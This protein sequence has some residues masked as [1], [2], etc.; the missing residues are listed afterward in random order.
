[1]RRALGHKSISQQRK[2]WLDDGDDLIINVL[3]RGQAKLIF[4]DKF[5]RQVS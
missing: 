5:Y 2:I 4:T 1:M 3:M